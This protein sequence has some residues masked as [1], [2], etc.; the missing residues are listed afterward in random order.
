M[1]KKWFVIIDN[2]QHGPFSPLAINT[3]RKNGKINDNT[4]IWSE[5][6]PDWL[7]LKDVMQFKYISDVS[8]TITVDKDLH[9]IPTNIKKTE[10]VSV[11]NNRQNHISTVTSKKI[12][13]FIAVAIIFIFVCIS[14]V[15][16]PKYNDK[17]NVSKSNNKR[18]TY[19]NASKIK[20][21]FSNIDKETK[22]FSFQGKT[23]DFIAKNKNADCNLEI[24]N[25]T[26]KEFLKSLN[27]YITD[28]D[29]KIEVF[30]TTFAKF[31]SPLDA[32]ISKL[33][34]ELDKYDVTPLFFKVVDNNG[35]TY[36]GYDDARNVNV[37]VRTKKKPLGTFGNQY[38]QATFRN[39]GKKTYGKNAFGVDVPVYIFVDEPGYDKIRNILGQKSE[40]RNTYEIY[41]NEKIEQLKN[42][43]ERERRIAEKRIIEN[44]Y[45]VLKTSFELDAI[46]KYFNYL[47][48]SE[49]DESAYYNYIESNVSSK[50]AKDVFRIKVKYNEEEKTLGDILTIYKKGSFNSE[51]FNM[52]FYK[53]AVIV[54]ELALLAPPFTDNIAILKTSDSVEE[55]YKYYENYI[56]MYGMPEGYYKNKG[57]G[58]DVMGREN[59][60][61]KIGWLWMYYI[62]SDNY[63]VSET[64]VI[65]GDE[66]GVIFDERNL[67]SIISNIQED[68]TIIFLK[69]PHKK[70]NKN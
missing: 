21:L 45:N 43:S 34:N 14:V 25:T 10:D 57:H 28:V 56:Q 32:E 42:K 69:R 65:L 1:E 24:L 15:F 54:Y 27:V 4:Y 33:E 41:F 38:I 3:L 47:K 9:E 70:I 51:N 39:T 11:K 20:E 37:C 61:K 35:D 30:N 23:D 18:N 58:S 48:V 68:E 31:M 2:K 63:Y 49:F 36:Y 26:S 62:K 29:K 6:M 40:E 7:Y 22:N 55:V 17:N 16:I 46:S 64:G 13:I 60:S 8:G 19:E 59:G 12:K 44:Y 50:K 53:N 5:G 67:V 66:M 52:P